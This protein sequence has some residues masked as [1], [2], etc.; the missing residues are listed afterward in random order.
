LKLTVA[1]KEGVF[2]LARAAFVAAIA[3]ARARISKARD[4]SLDGFDNVL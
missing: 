3:N 2:A 1:V 4:E